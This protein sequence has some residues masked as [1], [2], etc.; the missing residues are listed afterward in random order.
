MVNAFINFSSSSINASELSSKGGLVMSRQLEAGDQFTIVDWNHFQVAKDGKVLAEAPAVLEKGSYFIDKTVK[1]KGAKK[2]KAGLWTDGYNSEW[3]PAVLTG[4]F[5]SE[6][7]RNTVTE[8]VAK[9]ESVNIFEGCQSSVE[10]LHEQMKGLKKEAKEFTELVYGDH[11]MNDFER[12]RLLATTYPQGLTLK[13]VK[14]VDAY[15]RCYNATKKV[16]YFRRKKMY[17][18]EPVK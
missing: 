7:T 16:T 14:V 18:F 6:T 17:F 11:A 8:R 10:F 4:S 13:V 12:L 1:F 5:Y 9:G 2:S 3:T 15:I